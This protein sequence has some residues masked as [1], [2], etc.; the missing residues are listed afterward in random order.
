VDSLVQDLRFGLRSL[1]RAPGLAALIVLT[2][3][4]GIG[5]N[6]AIFSLM[7]QVLLRML[8]V[9][10][11]QELVLLDGPGPY[12]GRTENE[13]VFSVPMYRGLYAGSG[14]VLSG[15]FARYQQTATFVV[16]ERS[17]RV[18]AEL[19]SGDYFNVLG[20]GPALGRALGHDD[21]RLPGGH[22]H[23]VLSHAFWQRR[24]GG[25]A[26]VLNTAVRVNG[27]PM[28][29]VGVAAPG[30]NGVDISATVDLFVPLMMKAQMT[31]TWNDLDTWRSR[32]V[33]V[34]GRL[35][36]GVSREQ[37]AAA[38]N[39]VYRQLLQEDF[40]TIRAPS[41]GLKARFLSKTLVLHSGSKGRSEL[42]SQFSTPLVLLM[43]MVGLVLVI[44][45]ANVAN[46]LLARGASQRRETAIRLALGAG[47]GRVVRQRLV[48]SLILAA[49]GAMSGLLFAWWT[50]SVLIHTLPFD[51]AVRGLSAEPDA[52]VVAFAMAVSAITAI[53]CG[54][55]PALET[56][57]PALTHALK[58]EVGTVAGG[59]SHARVR[60]GLV[61]AQVALSALLLVGA[62]LFA[63]SLYNLR[64]LNPGFV[65][66]NLLQFSVD[67]ALSGYERERSIALL[68]Q[69][70]DQLAATPGVVSAS[71][72]VVP[73]MTD[74]NWSASVRVQGYERKEGEDVSPSVNGVGPAYFAT[75]GMA[76]VQGREFSA[77]DTAGAPKVAI[78]NETM[79]KYFWGRDNP[80]GRRFG[81]GRLENDHEIEVVGVVRDSKFTTLRAA[82][83]R[84][85]YIP[86]TQNDEFSA[87]TVYVR[88]RPEMTGAAS[89]ARQI[90][91]RLDPNLPIFDM[92]TMTAQVDE[93]LFLERLVAVLSMLFGALA[94]L[95]AAVG[96][97]G[98]MS[99]TVSRRTREIGI[100]MALGAERTSVLWMILR[101]V[102][103][104]AAAGVLIGLPV[105]WALGRLVESQLYGLSPTDPFT[106]IMAATA[107]SAVALLAGYV[108]A[109]RA[110]RV[111]PMLAI[112]DL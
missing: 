67:P 57:R 77:T 10:E 95:L 51:R 110:T 32:W 50:T 19:V 53:L 12:S 30:F 90:V 26:A 111:D 59:G 80:I 106:L 55:A 83:P 75:M 62:G 65:A 21:D 103:V 47:R 33:T 25:S 73:A 42:R 109:R 79:A 108:P 97:Y 23:V 61:V 9:R 24:F 20:V 54:L 17:E 107:L 102:A 45:C 1:R 100:R 48:E 82:V 16:G 40:D 15:M 84:F 101:E 35:Q 38:L 49:G 93:S 52:R 27:H 29:I 104:M 92:K 98:V 96:L 14:Q 28:T 64:S 31:P 112:R 8:P 44:A 81:F 76:L 18:E 74:S 71:M 88:T 94:T 56:T 68:G 72:A 89:A 36:P 87:M 91:Q 13:M 34:M 78:V 4:L 2:L 41:A 85:V 70:R 11:P 22:P 58:Q 63:R 60:K 69:V 66:D 105:A 7:D 43:A 5:A 86:Y 99:Y 46:L 37:A 6:T 39:V 3:G